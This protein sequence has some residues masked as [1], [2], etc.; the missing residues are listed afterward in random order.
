MLP[1]EA[2]DEDQL[3]KLCEV[4][5]EMPQINRKI[6]HFL[7]THLNKWDYDKIITIISTRL[8]DNILYST[9]Y[10]IEWSHFQNL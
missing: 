4:I 9:M 8:L 2:S 3:F 5:K 1:V 6:L 7:A 10:C